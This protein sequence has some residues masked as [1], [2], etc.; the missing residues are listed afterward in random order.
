MN[1]AETGFRRPLGNLGQTEF[2]PRILTAE[3]Q[4]CHVDFRPGSSL[5]VEPRNDLRLRATQ[6]G[7][8]GGVLVYFRAH[9]DDETVL[10]NSPR[11]PRTS[12]AWNGARAEQTRRRWSR[13]RRSRSSASCARTVGAQSP[14]DLASGSRMNW[15]TPYVVSDALVLRISPSGAFV[16]GE[17]TS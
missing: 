1:E 13:A 8:L 3:T 2:E 15:D 7:T 11:A 9:L 4:I 6:A 14:V 17:R 16:A 10:G 5:A 12:W